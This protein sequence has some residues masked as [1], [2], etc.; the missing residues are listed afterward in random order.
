MRELLV[1]AGEASGDALAAEVLD[2][3]GVASFGL[4]GPRVARAGAE[5]VSDVMPI[6]AMG[7]TA[8][9]Q[10]APRLAAAIGALAAAVRRRRPRAALL[11]GFSEVN[12]HLARWLKRRGTRTLWYA[13]PQVWAWR[14][15]RATRIAKD[16]DRIAV[17]LPFEAACWARSGAS[18]EYVGHPAMRRE[19]SGAVSARTIALL[20]GSRSHEVRAHLSPMLEAAAHF[21]PSGFAA[22]LVLAEGLDARTADWAEAAARARGVRT[23]RGGVGAIAGAAAAVVASG[24]ATLECAVLEVPPVI[25][26]RTDALTFAIATRLVS[27]EHV[28]L[29]NLVLGKRAFAELL[30]HDVRP[31]RIADALSDVLGEPERHR[32]L[33]RDVRAALRDPLGAMRPSQ[34][35]AERLRPWLA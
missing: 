1:V 31:R 16:C 20:P 14:P 29:P 26:Y 32:A 25:V 3:L 23:T 4:G 5:L 27:V 34:R 7:V 9:L 22:T 33:C 21:A 11:V 19:C 30:Q 15:G 17:L 10:R 24:T 6:A 12:A 18:V 13:P 35:V 8:A 28:G 2:E